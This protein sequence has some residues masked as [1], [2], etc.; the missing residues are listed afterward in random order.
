MDIK[1]DEL[2]YEGR[3]YVEKSALRAKRKYL[4]NRE[5]QPEARKPFI[6]AF[7]S[8]LKDLETLV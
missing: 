5:A 3:V 6:I 4:K 8:G 2:Y 7:V 1:A